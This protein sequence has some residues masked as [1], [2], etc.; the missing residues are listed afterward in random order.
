VQ[1]AQQPAHMGKYD[2]EHINGRYI[3]FLDLFEELIIDILIMLGS[4]A[5][6]L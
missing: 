1:F 4:F 3:S 2:I 6:Y 5:V